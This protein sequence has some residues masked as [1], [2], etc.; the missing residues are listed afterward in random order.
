MDIAANLLLVRLVVGLIFA[1]HG[2][3]KLFGWFGGKGLAGHAALLE[4]LDIR[5]AVPW[6]LAS[7]LS[8]F[9]GGL[10]FTVGLLM[11]LAAS[12]LVGSMVVAVVR[13][14]WSKGFWN[15]SGGIEYPLVL[16]VV[17]FVDGLSGPGEF[18]LDHALRIALPEPA[19][20]LWVLLL[21]AVVVAVSLLPAVA[22]HHH[23]HRTA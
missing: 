6:A 23:M 20:Y 21:T 22:S 9:L 3:Q 10:G 12:A 18:S 16:G 17:A 8:E 2:A 15:A 5:P 11:P 13:V 19:T 14:H 7:G 4:R 1:S